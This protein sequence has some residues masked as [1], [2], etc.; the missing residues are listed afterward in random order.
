VR[1]TNPH[2]IDAALSAPALSITSRGY[3]PTLLLHFV[4]ELTI[5]GLLWA[6][7]FHFA[8]HRVLGIL[9]RHKATRENVPLFRRSMGRPTATLALCRVLL[10]ANCDLFTH[11]HIVHLRWEGCTHVLWV[12]FT[13]ILRLVSSE[14]ASTF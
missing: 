9:V 6:V 3:I 4:C 11:V 8:C 12:Q 5:S 1:I 14:I 13:S 7:K 10:P 2:L